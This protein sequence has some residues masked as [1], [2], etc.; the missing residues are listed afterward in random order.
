M[1]LCLEILRGLREQLTYDRAMNEYGIGSVC[2]EEPIIPDEFSDGGYPAI[3]SGAEPE[4][5]GSVYYDDIS[6][7]PLPNDLVMK[8]IAEE[9]AQYHKHGVYEKCP[10]EQCLKRTGRKPIGVRWV[11]VN[12]GDDKN[13]NIR[14]RLVG[15][16]FKTD[17]PRKGPTNLL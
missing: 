5:H 6:G 12:K 14:A 2:C 3:D 13:P 8:A 9:M 16:E 17:A 4:C 1:K 11:I 15:K 10:I 7:A